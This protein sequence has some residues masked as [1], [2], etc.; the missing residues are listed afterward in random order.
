MPSFCCR[1]NNCPAESFPSGP[2]A[3]IG[4]AVVIFEASKSAR[5]S[6]VWISYPSDVNKRT[7]CDNTAEESEFLIIPSGAEISKTQTADA[8]YCPGKF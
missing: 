3:V 8:G 2:I 1:N 6:A 5:I 4:P 7:P